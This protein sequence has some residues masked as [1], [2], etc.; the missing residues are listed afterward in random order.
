MINN[1]K[2]KQIVET[3]VAGLGEDAPT[4]V[5]MHGLLCAF[6][7]GPY[8]SPADFDTALDSQL[9]APVLAALEE[10]RL[11]LFTDMMEGE[12]VSLPCLL[13][14]YK[15]DDGNDLASWCAGFLGGVFTHEDRWYAEDEAEVANWL[16]PMVLISGVDDDDALDELWNDSQLVRQMANGLPDLLEELLLHFQGPSGGEG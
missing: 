10:L 12:R 14:P 2:L 8:D 9:E 3:G 11:R 1:P 5:E 4:W 13:D 6:A 16:L 7:V 15:E